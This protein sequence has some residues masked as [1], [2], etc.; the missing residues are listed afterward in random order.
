MKT[1]KDAVNPLVMLILTATILY[2]RF[3]P[4]NVPA[5][6]PTVN[7]VALGK[8]Y[9]PVVLSTYADAW[10]AAAKTLEEGKTVAEAQKSLQETW[11]AGRVKA[12]TTEVAPVFAV[13]LPEGTEPTST[14][15]RAQVVELWR[16]FAKGLKGGH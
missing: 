8:T 7:A 9:G 4:R 6:T 13:V 2:D 16:S 3:V 15:K 14:D 11:K 10:L 5:P 12:F 1:L